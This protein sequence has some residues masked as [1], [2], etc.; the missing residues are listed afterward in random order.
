MLEWR[1]VRF[2]LWGAFLSLTWATNVL[3]APVCLPPGLPAE[4]VGLPSTRPRPP[5]TLHLY[6]DGSLSMAGYADGAAAN[7]RPLGDLLA[8]LDGLS[9][10]AKAPLTYERFG[11][12]RAPL[13][14][15]AALEFA[16]PKAYRCNGASGC[17]NQ[18]SR[19]DQVL[20]AV[21]SSPP[22]Q[23]G[24][25]VTDLWLSNTAFAGSPQVALGAPLTD[26]LQQGRAVGVLG[27]RAPFSGRLYD[28]PGQPMLKGSRPLFVLIIGREADVLAVRNAFAN[29]GSPAF[30]A[31]RSRFSVFSAAPTNP[32]RAAVKPVGSS[33]AGAVQSVVASDLM[34]P[35]L[36]QF[37]YRPSQGGSLVAVVDAAAG[38]PPNAVWSGPL[39]GATKV[40]VLADERALGRDC[41]KAWRPFGGLSNAWASVPGRPTAGRF[42]LSP[43]NSSVLL[44]GKTY[45]IA[46]SL[47]P[48]RL[49]TP[50]PAAGW[51]REWNLRSEDQ[52][53]VARRP[54]DFV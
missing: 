16:Q 41:G 3:A 31:D 27:V 24:I 15:T 6:L 33:G 48:K 50:N 54:P 30:S 2:G 46:A 37:R 51:M 44:P 19:I 11:A 14:K 17:D 26:L 21:R 38:P 23:V 8:I 49:D 32:W 1:R 10:R 22:G 5:V 18:E 9:E 47:A 35:S 4:A 39:A 25:V 29:S 13:S 53:G 7:V 28:L 43:G 34:A 36:Q 42:T 12:R 45:M 52:D 20:Q 40:W